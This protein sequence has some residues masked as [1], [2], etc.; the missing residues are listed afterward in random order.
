MH[1]GS[2]ISTFNKTTRKVERSYSC[3]DTV[4]QARAKRRPGCVA[5]AGHTFEDEH[6]LAANWEFVASPPADP[7]LPRSRAIVLDCEMSGARFNRSELVLLTA[8]D[9]FSGEVLIN[10]LVRPAVPILDWRTQYSGV[11]EARMLTAIADGNCLDGWLQARARLLEHA[12]ADT[13]LLGHSLNNDLDQLRLIHPRVVDSCLAI[14][15]LQGHKHSVKGLSRELLGKAVQARSAGGHDCLEDTFAARELVLWCLRRPDL[16]AARQAQHYIEQQ[17]AAA[18]QSGDEQRARATLA[19]IV[20]GDASDRPGIVGAGMQCGAA[21]AAE[22]GGGGEGGDGG[23][24]GTGLYA[25]GT[26]VELM[27]ARGR[28]TRTQG[29]L[30]SALLDT[31]ITLERLRRDVTLALEAGRVPPSV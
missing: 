19:A 13:V 20:D 5:L 23:G 7:Q 4:D 31:G 8:V 16:H 15:R 18:A 27:V 11:S 1:P 14:P 3:C 30:V 29:K 12:D 17:M 21:A 10:S 2:R 6:E 9:F 26:L 28:W 25:E 22:G 24:D